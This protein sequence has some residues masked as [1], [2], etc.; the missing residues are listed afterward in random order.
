MQNV[1]T[2]LSD[3]DVL[4]VPQRSPVESRSEVD[5][6]TTVAPGIDLDDPLLSAP[7]DTVTEAETAIALSRAG[8]FGTVHRVLTVDEQADQV[9]RVD[10]AG[11]RVGGAV[12]IDEDYFHR[13]ERCLEA[14]GESG[15]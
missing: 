6:S 11:E 8:G 4:L 14:G 2:G 9:R 12:G 15:T 10:D 1:R 13:A 7:M 3:G 5:L